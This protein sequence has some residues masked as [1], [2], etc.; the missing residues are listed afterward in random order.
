MIQKTKVNLGDRSYDIIIGENLIDNA[1]GYIKPFLNRAKTVI[2][3]DQ[4][5]AHHQLG[6]LEESLHNIDFTTIILPPGESTK[7][8]AQAEDLLNQLLAL[9]LERSDTIIAFGGG[10]IGDL[11]GF[12]AS[13]YLRGIDFIQIPTTLLAQVDSSVGGKT[14]INSNFGKNLIGS[15]W[16]PRLVLIDVTTLDTLNIRQVIAGYAEVVKYGLIDDAD[17]FK[18][19]EDNGHDL[20]SGSIEQQRSLR[21]EAILKS[22]TAKARV[23][24]QDEKETGNRALLNLGHTFAHALEAENGYNDALY[25]GEAV[26]MGIILAFELSLKMGLCQQHDVERIK[27]HFKTINTK[28]ISQFDFHVDHLLE[29][30]KGDKK[31]S[32]GKLTFVVARAI[33]GAYLS[34]E[35]DMNDVRAVLNHSFKKGS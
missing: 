24:G 26:A 34:N 6:R 2:I 17:F 19:L 18:W 21:T 12:V 32:D 3:T 15:F 4:N 16:Q 9:K 8:F 1:G 14:G 29:H 11:V 20:I 30:M 5:V 31:M 27:T 7:S 13:I 33:G 25:H 35:V 22:C 28:Q 23:V 10:V